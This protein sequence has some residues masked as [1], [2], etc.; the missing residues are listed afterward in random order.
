M[1]RFVHL[2]VSYLTVVGYF[3]TVT[4]GPAWHDHH[5]GCC[6]THLCSEGQVSSATQTPT[7]A[8]THLCSHDHGRCCDTL[9]TTKSETS[10][11]APCPA[12]CQDDDCVVCQTLAHPPLTTPTIAPVDA[13]EPVPGWV[14]PP[15]PEAAVSLPTAYDSRGPPT[16]V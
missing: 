9:H 1:S 2:A 7:H 12:P 10:E 14:M 11:H 6:Q 8:H 5:Q 4:W 13:S 15:C 16:V 3:L